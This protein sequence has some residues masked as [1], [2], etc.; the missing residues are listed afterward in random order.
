MAKTIHAHN[1]YSYH[2]FCASSGLKIDAVGGEA[3]SKHT[4]SWCSWAPCSVIGCRSAFRAVVRTASGRLLC[5]EHWTAERK[6]PEQAARNRLALQAA[7]VSLEVRELAR[8][9]RVGLDDQHEEV[10][11]WLERAQDLESVLYNFT[12][13]SWCHFRK[14][15]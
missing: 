12:H 11:H 4:D 2:G 15:D 8:L 3:C 9:A 7:R 5:E 13:P 6:H 14:R 10:A 1:G